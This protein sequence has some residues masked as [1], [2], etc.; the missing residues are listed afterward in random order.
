MKSIG[1]HAINGT[2]GAEI[3]DELKPQPGDYVVKKRRFSGFYGTDVDLCL[4]EL[5][6]N[7]LV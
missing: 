2:L 4:R 1:P 5:E 7:N 3:I 6:V